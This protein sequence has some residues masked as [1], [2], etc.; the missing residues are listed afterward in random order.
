MD[1]D[2]QALTP[3]PAAPL[4]FLVGCP[5]SGTYLL[6]AILNRSGRI[7]FPRETHF[8]PLFPPH[9]WLAGDLSRPAARRRLVRAVMMFLRIWLVRAEEERDPAELA[10]HSLLAIE[11]ESDRIAEAAGDYAELVRGLFAAYATSQGAALAGDKSPFFHHVPLETLDAAVG[12]QA[13]FIHIIRDGRDVGLSWMKIKVGPRSLDQAA[14]TW[15]QHVAGKRTWGALHP[16]RYYELCYE[17]LLAEPEKT[18]RAICRFVGIPYSDRMLEFHTSAFAVEIA[19]NTSQT[20]LGQPLDAHNCGKW[21]TEMTP[22]EVSSFEAIARAELASC[23]YPLAG[24][25][26]AEGWTHG[27]ATGFAP[28]HRLRLALKALLPACTL[29]AVRWGL[30]LDRLCNSRGWLNLD[31][32]RKTSA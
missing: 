23:G 10:R 31:L 28:I 18:L 27:R 6:S 30:Q 11:S 22:S 8:I 1:S 3:N 7:A 12:G 5:R 15:A 4:Y 20:R 25:A 2:A 26:S 13:R 21:K 24:G 16:D 19:A 17:D 29:V 32:C 9:L 14:R